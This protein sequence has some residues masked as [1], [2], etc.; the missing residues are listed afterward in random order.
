MTTAACSTTSAQTSSSSLR[1]FTSFAE[2]FGI[3]LREQARYGHF[4]DGF[5]TEW[6]GLLRPLLIEA[7]CPPE[8]SEPLGTLILGSFRGLYM[9]LLVTGDRQRADRAAAELAVATRLLIDDTAG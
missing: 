5:V 2:V 7:G 9:D 1:S 4:L 3:A 8:R 6:L